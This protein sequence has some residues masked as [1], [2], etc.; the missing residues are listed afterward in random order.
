[1]TPL[2]VDGMVQCDA[3]CTT[4]ARMPTDGLQKMIIPDT[5]KMAFGEWNGELISSVDSASYM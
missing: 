5:R 3:F 4:R 2:G 1:M